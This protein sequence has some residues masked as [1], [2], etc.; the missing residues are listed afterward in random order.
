MP[1]LEGLGKSQVHP[2]LNQPAAYS[3][4]SCL[5]GW[6]SRFPSR[7]GSLVALDGFPVLPSPPGP[8]FHPQPTL[9]SAGIQTISPGSVRFSS[10]L[11]SP[12]ELILRFLLQ[13]FLMPS[14]VCS[15]HYSHGTL[16]S[17][18]EVPAFLSLC[19]LISLLQLLFLL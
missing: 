12:P 17:P 16:V 13:G 4:I 5:T 6:C 1:A 19:F 9:L 10:L 2:Y 15:P 7:P 18:E 3:L 11:E 8:L 14:Y